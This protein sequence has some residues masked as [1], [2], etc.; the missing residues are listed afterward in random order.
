MKYQRATW[1][2][3]PATLAIGKSAIRRRDRVM[4]QPAR[5]KEDGRVPSKRQAEKDIRAFLQRT[6]QYHSSDAGK[7]GVF[8]K[9]QNLRAAL[10]RQEATLMSWPDSAGNRR[11]RESL[12]QAKAMVAQQIED[13]GRKTEAR[14]AKPDTESA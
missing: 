11:M 2:D 5:T 1:G 6:L 12:A 7:A 3:D 9:L 8:E 13:I 4:A 10:D 14:I